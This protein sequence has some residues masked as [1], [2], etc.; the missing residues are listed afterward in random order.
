MKYCKYATYALIAFPS[1]LLSFVNA[2]YSSFFCS[3]IPFTYLFLLAFS[4]APLTLLPSNWTFAKLHNLKWATRMTGLCPKTPSPIFIIYFY[5]I[6]DNP[7]L[8]FLLIKNLSLTYQVGAR[9]RGSSCA[10]TVQ[11]Y[12]AA[13]GVTGGRTVRRARTRPTAP[14]SPSLRSRSRDH[15][16]LYPQHRINQS[17]RNQSNG[18]A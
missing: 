3:S 7:Y 13:T 18:S 17:Y 15:Q 4:L 11:R 6:L 8:T 9:L 5:N 2:L 10:T 1:P 12:A 14:S 16:V